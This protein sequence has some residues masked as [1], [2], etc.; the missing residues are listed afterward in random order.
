MANKLLD[1]N[2]DGFEDLL[3]D[4]VVEEDEAEFEES[5]GS[6]DEAE[7]GDDGDG[8]EDDGGDGPEDEPERK[9]VRGSRSG[10]RTLKAENARIREINRKR[11]EE[12]ATLEAER[13][14]L[15]AILKAEEP[16]DLEEQE[17][18][19]TERATASVRSKVVDAQ[20]ERQRQQEQAEEMAE[21][22]AEFFEGI[23]AERARIPD[24]DEVV[25]SPKVYMPEKTTELLVGM[26]KEGAAL[27]YKLAKNPEMTRKIEALAQHN[28]AK[29][30][31]AIADLK[32]AR[33][34]PRKVTSAPAP[35]DR[36]G[37]GGGGAGGPDPYA[38]KTQ[39]AYEAARM[40]QNG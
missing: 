14:A 8:G 30:A 35:I 10:S 12:I 37:G 13:D 22:S 29:A 25:L 34:K 6:E 38:A 40:K 2:T 4:G 19:A 33:K 18:W 20:I 7:E 36:V 21:E 9:R 16:E 1:M 31:L 28:M 39:A 17:L 26:G 3:E 15:Q 24:F 27:S 11:K 5:E 23:E 32:N